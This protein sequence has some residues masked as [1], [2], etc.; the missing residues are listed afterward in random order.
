MFFLHCIFDHIN[1]ALVSRRDVHILPIYFILQYDELLYGKSCVKMH[2]NYLIV[3]HGNRFGTTWVKKYQH[4]HFWV[5]YSV[6]SSPEVWLFVCNIDF[7]EMQELVS[8]QKQIIW[9]EANPA[10]NTVQDFAKKISSHR[11][12]WHNGLV[13]HLF[14]FSRVASSWK[15]RVNPDCHSQMSSQP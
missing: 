9:Y 15:Q 5:T 12:P 14:V 6:K 2:Q 4:L 10:S 13:I 3:F 11:S 8:Q 7:G 1:A